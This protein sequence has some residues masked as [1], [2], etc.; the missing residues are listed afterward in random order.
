MSSSTSVT[1]PCKRGGT[2]WLDCSRD[3]TNWHGQPEVSALCKS[4]AVQHTSSRNANPRHAQHIP[5]TSSSSLIDYRRLSRMQML[6]M[7]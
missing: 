4:V 2:G 6:G 3:H 1:Q 7:V 5:G